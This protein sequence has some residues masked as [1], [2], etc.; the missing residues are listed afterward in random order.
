MGHGRRKAHPRE[1]GELTGETV[2]GM[3]NHALS[4]AV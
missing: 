4:I 3:S 2:E 1:G